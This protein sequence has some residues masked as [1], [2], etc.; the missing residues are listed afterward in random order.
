MGNQAPKQVK[1]TDN[2]RRA[3]WAEL[4]L[5]TFSRRAGTLPDFNASD[6]ERAIALVDLLTDLAHW[7]DRNNV[8]MK[9]TI[10]SATAHYQ[11][12][13]ESRGTQLA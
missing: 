9:Q 10:M 12:E 8:S 5:Q 11:A 13:T 4:T 7:C 6:E 2:D 1:P 3:S